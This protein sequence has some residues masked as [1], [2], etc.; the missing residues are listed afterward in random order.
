MPRPGPRPYECVR[1]AWHSDRHQPMRGSLIQ[2]IF[3]VV[4]EAH[5][6]ATRRNREWQDKLPCV[7][8]R[9][10]EIIYSKANSEAEYMDPKTLWSRAIDAIDTIIRRD[11]ANE[12]QDLLQPCIEAALNLGCTPRRASRSQRHSNPGCYLSFSGSRDG[13]NVP[14]KITDQSKVHHLG[15]SATLLPPMPS[16]S[17]DLQNSSSQLYSSLI[18]SST[19]N[20]AC[21]EVE[22]FAVNASSELKDCPTNSIHEYPFPSNSSLLT[23]QPAGLYTPVETCTWP[24]Y[25]RVYPLFYGE[26]QIRTGDEQCAQKP[27]DVTYNSATTVDP[28]ILPVRLVEMDFLH[29]FLGS[30]PTTDAKS[31][32]SKIEEHST[33]LPNTSCSLSLGLGLPVPSALAAE[34]AWAHRFEDMASDDSYEGKSSCY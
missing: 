29:N 21:R 19:P 12:S 28:S 4:N 27:H 7:V 18:T 30:S 3:R 1:R 25:G 31:R 9:A 15:S 23:W 6:P 24:S 5:S 16:H 13:S 10:E 32:A 8:L 33:R 26:P 11:D 34:N 17:T 14:H 20:L 22:T 2:E